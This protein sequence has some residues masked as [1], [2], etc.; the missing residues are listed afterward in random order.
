MAA[1]RSSRG[2]LDD[3]VAERA[4]MVPNLRLDDEMAGG[5]AEPGGEDA[6]VGAGRAAA[7]E[8]AEDDAAGLE[9][10]LV[11]DLLGDDVAD[12]RRGGRGRRGRCSVVEGD[13]ALVGELGPFGD[14]DD[15]VVLA[16]RP[17]GA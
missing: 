8:V 12:A 6:V 15:A 10:G 4:T 2:V 13:D 1:T 3:L 17:G 11:L 9:A 16:L 5:E 14:D 7:L